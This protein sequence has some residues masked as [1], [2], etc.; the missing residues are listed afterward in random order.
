[1]SHRWD[2]KVINESTNEWVTHLMNKLINVSQLPKIPHTLQH[3]LTLWFT[4]CGI[5][6]SWEAETKFPVADSTDWWLWTGRSSI[7]GSVCFHMLQCCSLHTVAVFITRNEN[8]CLVDGPFGLILR[9][10]P[11][12]MYVKW[13][14]YLL[15]SFLA[16]FP[17]PQKKTMALWENH[18]L[19]LFLPFQPYNYLIDLYKNWYKSYVFER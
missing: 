2:N 4:D 16:Y 3:I 9:Y 19:Y 8:W 18:T 1:M 12:R 6:N 15:V 7:R 14:M 11:S 17:P 10:L 13:C 5:S